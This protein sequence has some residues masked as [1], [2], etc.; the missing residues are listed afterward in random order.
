[1]AVAI[2][3]LQ[4]KIM[5]DVVDK[6]IISLGITKEP[7]VLELAAKHNKT[8]SQIILNW[9]LS[10]GYVAIPRTSTLSR[11]R[12][13]LESDT[14]EMTPEEIKKISALNKNARVWDLK[15]M[16]MAGNVPVFA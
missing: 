8:P 2:L 4:V 7:V 1:M 10:R 14:F 6:L 16:E 5:I 9:H 3:S 12:E 15:D 11:L 13:N